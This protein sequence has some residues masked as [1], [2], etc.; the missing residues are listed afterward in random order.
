MGK[1]G[2]PKI[3]FLADECV[4]A[5]TIHLLRDLEYEVSTVWDINLRGA[6]NGTLLKQ[7][8]SKGRIFI[9][10]DQ[11]FLNIILYPPHLHRGVIVL[12]TSPKVAN[13]VRA[14]LKQLLSE[15]KPSEFGKTL[16]VVDHKSFRL[17]R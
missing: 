14:I 6:T 5:K 16:V 12:K 9:T 15:L 17:R 2:N 8:I 10:E 11:D 4:N 13:E 1:P 3:S 7:A